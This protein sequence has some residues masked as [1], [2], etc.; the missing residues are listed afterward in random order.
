MEALCAALRAEGAVDDMPVWAHADRR[1]RLWQ[2]YG[3]LRRE[4]LAAGWDARP[5]EGTHQLVQQRDGGLD[6][7]W[8][9]ADRE[10]GQ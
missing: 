5:G 3:L 7:A 8:R 10:A 4:W 1:T 6:W 9:P 2:L